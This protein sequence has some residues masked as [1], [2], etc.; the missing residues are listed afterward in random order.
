MS[1]LATDE[2]IRTQRS[3]SSSSS[4]TVP[5]VLPTTWLPTH[6]DYHEAP[7]RP[8]VDV[9]GCC[10]GEAG[11]VDS[12]PSSS[13]SMTAG[14]IFQ[15]QRIG[16]MPQMTTAD[17]LQVLD[18]AVQ[19]W[20]RG[21]GTWPQ[22]SLRERCTA[23][24]LFLR[25][26]VQIREAMADILMWEIGK[27]RPDALAEIDRTIQFAKQAIDMAQSDPEFSGEQWQVIGATH[28]LVRRSGIGVILCLA[29][30]NYPINESYAA[31]IPALITGNIILVKIPAV[32]GLA[33]LLTMEALAKTLPPGTVN[34]IAGSGRATMP[35]IMKTGLVDGL[36]FIGG[37]RAA[38]DLIHQH[39]HP[40]RLKVFLQLEANNMGIMLKDLFE[41]KNE[42]WLENA[43][44]ESILGSLSFN[45]QRC[46]ALKLFFA[47]SQYAPIFAQRLATKVEAISIGLPWQ[48]HAKNNPNGETVMEYSSVTPL[49]NDD[50]IKYMKSL[51]DDAVSK[52]ATIINKD[53]GSIIGGDESTLMV[54]AVLYPVTSEMKVYHEE[55][56][57]PV[58]PI[59][60]YNDLEEVLRFGQ[61]GPY[62]QQVSVFTKD[63]LY[64]AKILDRFSS[65]YGKVNL[66]SQCGR[67]PDTLPFAG[68]R[69]SAMGVMSVRD[70]LREF[71][72]PTVIAYKEA[73]ELDHE[74]VAR[75]LQQESVFLQPVVD[76]PT[77]I[78]AQN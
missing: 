64:A 61:D 60:A 19:A 42:A 77:T 67:S 74:S 50:R 70:A 31:I 48:M 29:P 7:K 11:T 58:I 62:A 35:P 76:R 2:K 21:A 20:D 63:G 41:P 53:G 9:T 54:P 32:G 55:Q 72:V 14:M 1:V 33:H 24:Q 12:S 68:R 23:I 78:Q 73:A 34:F 51:I 16:K 59:A 71:S 46:T 18:Y 25:E 26:L 56:F 36:A 27:N 4:P 69:S 44:K 39:P 38:D 43:L 15:K 45:G 5:Y 75:T 3:S 30:Y 52:G 66:N 49:P 65:V 22:T 57:G 17:A 47:P 13:S 8:W 28:A 37:S 40:H 10:V 6:V